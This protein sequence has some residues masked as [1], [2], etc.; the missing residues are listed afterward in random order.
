LSFKDFTIL[1]ILGQGAFGRVYHVIP[2]FSASPLGLISKSKLQAGL[3]SPMI[4]QL[5]GGIGAH[6]ESNSSVES[7]QSQVPVISRMRS[8]S[9]P[10]T[11]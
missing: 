3:A 1:S 4:L 10:S 6:E 5:K 8:I 2:K 11:S 9:G 7:G